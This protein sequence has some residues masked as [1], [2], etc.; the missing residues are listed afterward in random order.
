MFERAVEKRSFWRWPL[1][2]ACVFALYSLVRAIIGYAPES[3][4][5]FFLPM[6][7]PIALAWIPA[8]VNAG[9]F[10]MLFVLLFGN[11]KSQH[12]LTS[13]DEKDD[14]IVAVL[15][16]LLMSLV[17]SGIYSMNN[18]ILSSV[19]LG[20]ICLFWLEWSFD[21]RA[22][23]VY[24][25]VLGWTHNLLVQTSDHGFAY[26]LFIS[27]IESVLAAAFYLTCLIIFIIVAALLSWGLAYGFKFS[28]PE[29]SLIEGT[30][31]TIHHIPSLE[32]VDKV[33]PMPRATEPDPDAE[34]DE[35]GIRDMETL[36][37]EV[38]SL[39]DA[40]DSPSDHNQAPNDAQDTP[41]E[42]GANPTADTTTEES[43]PDKYPT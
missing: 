8:A 30:S 21:Y 6:E 39:I 29:D 26:S 9:L 18:L 41:S 36:D 32:L 2:T 4:H 13:T 12:M 1:T 17:F 33:A 40:S 11:K 15:S 23:V 25:A 24:V 28:F 3:N 19:L 31:P 5:L 42:E 7:F 22:A 16:G 20:L 35:A 34:Y 14:Y 27:P 43:T 37:D 10:V 38:E